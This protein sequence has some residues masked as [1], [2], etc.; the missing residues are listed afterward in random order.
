MTAPYWRARV[1]AL[2]NRFGYR[3]ERLRPTS[4]DPFNDQ[5]SLLRHAGVAP[6][7]VLDL[8]A[9]VGTTVARYRRLF[10]D[11]RIFAF[12]PAPAAFE[13]LQRATRLDH[14]TKSINSAVSEHDGSSR[15]HLF[16][17]EQANSLFPADA[18][19]G[20]YYHE[21]MFREVD[22]IDVETV[23]L[24]SF[25][26]AEA[27]EH[28]DVLKMDIQGAELAA[29]RG[30][31]EHLAA[32]RVT[33]LYFEVEFAPVYE[34]QATFY[35]IREFLAT[36]GYDMFNLYGMYHSPNGRLVAADTIF[37]RSDLIETMSRGRM[38]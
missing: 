31:R 24:D 34:G 7:V 26:R 5:A 33:L 20:S 1:Q 17:H 35:E 4:T 14:A 23:S 21:A 15:L 2:L 9:Y 19:A 18:A 22:A 28:V 8:G 16:S 3:V 37:L 27:I 29:L 32:G 10:P 6:K 30:A 12:E 25:C 38:A 11:A 13:R 36:L